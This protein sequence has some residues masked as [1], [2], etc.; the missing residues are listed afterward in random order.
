MLPIP[1]RIILPLLLA[2]WIIAANAYASYA[3]ITDSGLYTWLASRQLSLFGSYGVKS[4]WCLLCII[5][6]VPSLLLRLVFK[7]DFGL[8]GNFV[9]FMDQQRAPWSAGKCLMATLFCIGVSGVSWAVAQLLPDPATRPVTLKLSELGDGVPPL[10]MVR[11]VG[12][13]DKEHTVT[14]R[15]QNSYNR[16][17]DSWTLYM[18]MRIPGY[19]GTTYRYFVGIEGVKSP[20]DVEPLTLKG[21]PE[22]QEM[23]RKMIAALDEKSRQYVEEFQADRQPG[24]W[25]GLLKEGRLP[26]TVAS[27]FAEQGVKI[28]EPHYFLTT[29]ERNRKPFYTFSQVVGLLG[30]VIPYMGWKARR[31]SRV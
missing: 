6:T 29:A 13:F 9:S 12:E 15:T 18:P 23:E 2:V 26:G 20:D 31:R 22:H 16:S 30:L 14:I 5:L 4:T 8:A 25:R 1:S 24:T 28:A 10:G 17:K 11:L 7:P 19:S 21:T 3:F 27:L